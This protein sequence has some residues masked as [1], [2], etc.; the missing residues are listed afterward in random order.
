MC[1]PVA[2]TPRA[3]HGDDKV[4]ATPH[5]VP[6]GEMWITTTC[7][8]CGK[9]QRSPKF[10]CPTCDRELPLSSPLLRESLEGGRPASWAEEAGE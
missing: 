6:T 3:P 9:K 1:S 2:F 7:G 8:D 5:S 10:V 4:P